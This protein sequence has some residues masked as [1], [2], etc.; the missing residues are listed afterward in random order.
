MG[1]DFTALT[2]V[3]ILGQLYMSSEVIW[4]LRDEREATRLLKNN[5]QKAQEPVSTKP[6]SKY[7]CQKSKRNLPAL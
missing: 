5:M 7:G 3:A 1:M 2:M 4:I 6:Q